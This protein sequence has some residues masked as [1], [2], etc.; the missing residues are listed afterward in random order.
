MANRGRLSDGFLV[1]L[2]CLFRKR[3]RDKATFPEL[4]SLPCGCLSP[5]SPGILY[6]ADVLLITG[7]THQLRAQFAAEGSPLFGDSRYAPLSPIISRIDPYKIEGAERTMEY[8]SFRATQSHLNNFMGRGRRHSDQRECP[9]AR[10]EEY[11]QFQDKSWKK[12][13]TEQEGFRRDVFASSLRP[14]RTE[15][16]PEVGSED[17]DRSSG[18]GMDPLSQREVAAH[19]SSSGVGQDASDTGTSLSLHC[20]LQRR[21]ALNRHFSHTTPKSM[22]RISG[23]TFDLMRCERRWRPTQDL[24]TADQLA[25][26]EIRDVWEVMALCEEP[27]APIGLHA[28]ALHVEGLMRV[29]AGKPWWRGGMY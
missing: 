22:A 3:T 28:A 21:N 27:R 10:A 24:S 9:W 14:Q 25:E 29:E 17:N 16:V 19:P 26:L 8:R 23:G 12:R 2:W 15:S 7:R 11:H 4:F 20:H 6:E 18:S 5:A 1:D 13:E